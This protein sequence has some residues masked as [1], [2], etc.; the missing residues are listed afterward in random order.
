MA[1]EGGGRE[2]GEDHPNPFLLLPAELMFRVELM[3]SVQDLMLLN[4]VSVDMRDRMS[5][6]HWRRLFLERWGA[7]DR[8]DQR[9][10]KLGG[11][12]LLL[13][14]GGVMASLGNCWCR[15]WSTVERCFMRD[16]SVMPDD[17]DDDMFHGKQEPSWSV[18][19]FGMMQP[20]GWPM[21]SK[22]A[23]L[24]P[25]RANSAFPPPWKLAC[26]YRERS[27]N[28]VLQ[29]RC[30]NEVDVL[31]KRVKSWESLPTQSAT[32][33]RP[34]LCASMTHRQCLESLALPGG[35]S[36]PQKCGWMSFDSASPAEIG[37]CQWPLTGDHNECASCGH[38]YEAGWR[39][40]RSMR[41]LVSVTVRDSVAW[42][43]ALSCLVYWFALILLVHLLERWTGDGASIGL[44]AWP[45]PGG[46]WLAWWLL[47]QVM[48][49]QIFF[50][51]RFV[52]VVGCLWGGP[53]FSFYL[54]LYSY[55]FVACALFKMTWTPMLP[56]MFPTLIGRTLPLWLSCVAW[57]NAVIYLG[58][59]SVVIL[60]FWKTNYR[61]IT[62]ADRSGATQLPSHPMLQLK[63]RAPYWVSS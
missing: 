50:S 4:S 58:V 25:R 41:E 45:E 15:F 36:H 43:R 42:G 34:C 32:W 51:P 52:D 60:L 61:V 7:R 17:D 47:Q 28:V 35:L 10:A 62:V 63:P 33:V 1:A 46:L 31:T 13:S 24:S 14:G 56:R 29:C 9:Q 22:A 49:L 38:R 18:Q 23:L 2:M 39:L 40:P 16:P 11:C 53:F 30:C 55:F 48:L 6:T 8:G 5:P 21:R 59:S 26:L 27:D 44:I 57:A 54:K 3:L 37:L 19:F 20:P 12:L